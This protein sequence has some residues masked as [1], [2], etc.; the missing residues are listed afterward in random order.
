MHLDFI[1]VGPY[2]TGTSWIYEYLKNHSQVSLPLTVKETYFFDEKFSKGKEWYLSHFRTKNSSQ[3]FCD[4]SPSY[5][6]SAEATNNLYEFSPDAQVIVTLREPLDRLVSYYLHMLSKGDIESSTSFIKA[7]DMKKLLVESSL[8]YKHLSRWIERFGYDQVTVMYYEDFKLDNFKFCQSICEKLDI[9]FS[10]TDD[11]F[12][13]RIN[14]ATTPVN[15]KLARLASRTNRWLRH[16]EMH[17]IVNAVKH[18]PLKSLIYR[19]G[20]ASINI[21][22]DELNIAFEYIRNEMKNLETLDVN[23]DM[24]KVS[25]QNKRVI[26]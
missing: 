17:G 22:A 5:F 6:H 21:S 24:W 3:I 12:E 19:D 18:T 4:V 10:T 1:F 11:L 20:K 13:K 16:H 25:W 9:N 14:S 8:Y 7:L 2:K 26:F 23:L 15:F